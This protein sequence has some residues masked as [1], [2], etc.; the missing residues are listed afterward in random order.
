MQRG[1]EAGQR[2]HVEPD[3]V[4]IVINTISVEI[5]G[6]LAETTLSLGH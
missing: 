2:D 1:Q 6:Q 3:F 4:Q 5:V